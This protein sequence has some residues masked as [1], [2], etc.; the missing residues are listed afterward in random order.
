MDGT[1]LGVCSIV[2]FGISSVEVSDSVTRELI[3][4][5]QV[6]RIGGG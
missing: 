5:S 1:V 2:G 4:Y 3:N 6:V